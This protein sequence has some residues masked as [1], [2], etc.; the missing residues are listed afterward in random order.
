MRKIIGNGLESR[1]SALLAVTVLI[2]AQAGCNKADTVVPGGGQAMEKVTVRLLKI[3][4]GTITD[5]YTDS[6]ILEGIQEAVVTPSVPGKLLEFTVNEGD[7]VK[8]GDIMAYLEASDYDLEFG[9]AQILAKGRRKAFE[10]AKDLYSRNALSQAE[11]DAAEIEYKLAMSQL[12]QAKL[13]LDRTAIKS[14]LDGTVTLKSRVVGDRVTPGTPIF[15]VVDTDRMKL[16]VSLSEKEVVNLNQQDDVSV[17]VD[18]FP[19]ERFAGRIK[20]VRISP[21]AGT[22]S[23]PVEMELE[24]DGK[25]KPGMVARVTLRGR[26]YEGLLLIPTEAILERT[27]FEYVF[28]YEGGFAY[29]REVQSGRRFGDLTEIVKGLK[30]GD[31]IVSVYSSALTDGAPLNVINGELLENRAG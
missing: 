23:F 12:A 22:A 13:N 14:P 11:Y 17:E 2:L 19:G 27:G 1:I 4:P 21:V 15:R 26:I 10:R 24:A 16:T 3:E 7:R 30:P 31:Y 20:S 18:A 25:L 5:T 9:R 29:L 8:K 28:V 6:G